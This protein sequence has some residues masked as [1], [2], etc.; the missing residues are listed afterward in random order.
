MLTRLHAAGRYALAGLGAAALAGLAQAGITLDIGGTQLP[1]A[2]I[3]FSVSQQPVYDP[4]TYQ[5]I[6]PSSTELMAGAIYV[7]RS[8]DAASA[9]IIAHVVEGRRVPTIQ[10]TMTSETSPVRQVWTLEEAA[11]NNYSTYSAEGADIMENF[12]IS[13]SKAT[14][15]VFTGPGA[16][17]S[18]TVSWSA[19]AAGPGVHPH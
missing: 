12:D 3:S 10:I 17:P 2:S 5:P 13:Y 14:L 4:V 15:S 9:G 7:T 6:D 18:A 8:F 19:S 16:Q 1:A 11:L